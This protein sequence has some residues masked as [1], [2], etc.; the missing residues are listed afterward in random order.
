[1]PTHYE[2]LTET[3]YKAS[4][5][6]KARRFVEEAAKGLPSDRLWEIL[7][8]A[9]QSGISIEE[10]PAIELEWMSLLFHRQALEYGSEYMFS[11]G[12]LARSRSF[13]KAMDL[14]MEHMDKNSSDYG[15]RLLT[16]VAHYHLLTF[17]MAGK[18]VY[19]VSPGLGEKLA[20]TELRGVM[21]SDLRLPYE[22]IYLIVPKLAGLR[23]WNEE[24]GWHSL[25]GV[26]LAEDRY[27]LGGST[28]SVRGW[29]IF[30]VGEGRNNDDLDDAVYFFTIALPDDQTV[31]EALKALSV[32]MVQDI[33][34]ANRNG[35]QLRGPDENSWR[36]IFKW[37]MN[38]ML[39]TTW[40]DPGEHWIS[41]KEARQLW[42]RIQKAKGKKRGELHKRFASLDPKRRIILGK[43]IIVDRRLPKESEEA[44]E[45]GSSSSSVVRVRVSGHWRNQAYGKGRSE[46]KLIWIEPFWRGPEDGLWASQQHTLK[47]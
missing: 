19:D 43:G 27:V 41:N 24:T 28:S 44:S 46:H 42:D 36:S 39:Y 26:Y 22:A 25:V 32:R 34:R 29:R 21:C 18:R 23:V 8:M 4:L 7:V 3:Y 38:A 45:R 5:R 35:R 33:E 16:L 1:M 13:N 15:S 37:S 40:T 11:Y 47:G 30:V 20:H 9:A 10:G 12:L 31:D 6:S 17:E 2:V 14:F